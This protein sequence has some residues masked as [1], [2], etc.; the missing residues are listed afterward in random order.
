MVPAEA[1]GVG[2]EGQV[3]PRL[4]GGA[5]DVGHRAFARAGDAKA[6]AMHRR[7]GLQA[8]RHVVE[9]GLHDLGHARHD[10]DVVDLKAGRAADR[11]GDQDAAFGHA[12]HAA[13]GGVELAGRIAALEDGERLGVFA[14]RHAEDRADGV[15]GDVV[16]GRADAAGGEDIVVRG[17]QGVQGRDDLVLTVA[18]HPGLHQIDAQRGQKAGQGVHIAVTGAA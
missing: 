10:E 4:S 12:G 8:R 7:A 14:D 9:H 5:Q 2:A 17:A 15:G 13:A 11:I 1:E 3:R 6:A 18:D 16:M